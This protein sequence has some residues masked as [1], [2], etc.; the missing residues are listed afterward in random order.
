MF[1]QLEAFISERPCGQAHAPSICCVPSK[2]ISGVLFA[3]FNVI[4]FAGNH[5]LDAGVDA[6]GDTLVTLR[7]NG[8]S[9]VGAGMNLEEARQPFIKE[10]GA[11]RASP[12]L[13][14]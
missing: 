5:T 4:S 8:I 11:P 14:A 3:G 9:V 10:C 2:S 7:S 6:M 1:S 13:S 12:W